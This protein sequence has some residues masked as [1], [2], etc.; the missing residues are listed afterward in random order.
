MAVKLSIFND[1]LVLVLKA[2]LT[3]RFNEMFDHQ[4]L[5]EAYS[6]AFYRS[7]ST[8]SL[9]DDHDDHDDQAH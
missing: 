7:I 8:Q 5:S 6:F 3:Q 9:T 2:G 1:S 4:F